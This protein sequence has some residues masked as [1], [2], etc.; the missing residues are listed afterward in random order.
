MKSPYYFYFIIMD[1]KA[2]RRSVFEIRADI[3]YQVKSGIDLPT[4]IMYAVQYSWKP[5]CSYLDEL[6]RKGL[7]D[8]SV[9]AGGN[10]G[11][12]RYRIT[13]KGEDYLSCLS[14]AKHLL[15]VESIS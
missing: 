10:G 8:Y 1:V 6:A 3:L 2:M 11:K 9:P 5:L 14:E 7:V 4:R 15:S 12:K 13:E